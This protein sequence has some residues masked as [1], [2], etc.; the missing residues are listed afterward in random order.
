M[1]VGAG[2]AQAA[3]VTVNV[4]GINYSITPSYSTFDSILSSAGNP[5]TSRM[6]WYG[7][8]TLADDF[9]TAVNSQTFQ[10][11]LYSDPN[12]GDINVGPLFPWS[13]TVFSAWDTDNGALLSNKTFNSADQYYFALVD[14][15][16]PVPTPGPLPL[17]GA[18]AAFSAS[19][20]LRN[21]IPSKTFHF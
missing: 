13:S 5:P 12:D 3:T 17:L 4:G 21:R 16:P 7:S 6:P 19:R 10:T 2:A 15:A 20:K 8:S 11:Q 18:A 14:I 1:F 9:A